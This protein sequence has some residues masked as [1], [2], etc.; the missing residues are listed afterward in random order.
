MLKKFTINKKIVKRIIALVLVLAIG[1]GGFFTYRHFSSKKMPDFPMNESRLTEKV[2]KGEI[3]ESITASGMVYLADETEVYAE[4]E[5]NIIKEFLVE[6]GD[7][8]TEGQLLVNY[9]VKD[10]KEELEEKIKET[11]LNLENSNLSLKSLVL[12][13]SDSELKSLQSEITKA[14]KTLY[15]SNT[16]LENSDT[17]ISQAQT[18]LNNAKND[19]DKAEKTVNENKELLEIGGISQSDY[20]DSVDAYN[21]AKDTYNDALTALNQTKQDK[22]T[23]E[24]AV[25]TA[26]NALDEANNKL[27]LANDVFSD[28]ET[29]IK[30]QQQLISI[31]QT[32]NTLANYEKDLS[33]LVYST[34]SPVSGLVTEICVDEGTYT[35][36][37]TVMLKVADFNKLIVKAS[38]AEYDA[39]NL[40]LGQS[41]TMTSDGLEGKTYTGKITKINPS[42]S[43][44]STNMG[45][46]TVVPIEISVDNPDG[47][48]KPGY[49]LDLEIL[50]IDKNDILTISSSTLQ[51]ENDKY[52]V[53][54]VED[55]KIK[56][57]NVEIGTYGETVSEVL[58]GLNEND[59]VVASPSKEMKDGMSLEDIK[60]MSKPEQK[61]TDNT[62]KEDNQNDKNFGFNQG[63]QSGGN[64][65]QGF[66]GGMPPR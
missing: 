10:K 35:E 58:S 38:I 3:K 18:T 43:A 19:M 17:K 63:I 56:K 20:D 7:S 49:N 32:E 2:S 45:S 8:V 14:E 21:K 27:T 66:G 47:V 42:A 46:E 5:S 26:Q 60:N 9:D 57:T 16:S 53:Y 29:K 37:N 12:P 34:S 52:Y 50:Y 40:A 65:G 51:K 30:Y 64:R 59:E 33:E 61:S 62:K 31:Q 11:K 41:V 48:L 22:T 24:Y 55:N 23:A 28:E 44:E 4:G 6:E 25:K 13:T 39:P 54:K 1:F 36:E 15:E